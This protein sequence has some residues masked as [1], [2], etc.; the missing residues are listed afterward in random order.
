MLTENKD[1]AKSNFGINR[2]IPTNFRGMT[3]EQ[4]EKILNAQKIQQKELE[5]IIQKP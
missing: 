1:C 4:I 5:V 2:I 3:D